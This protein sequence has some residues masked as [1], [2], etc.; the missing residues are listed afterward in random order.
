M[1]DRSPDFPDLNPKAAFSSGQKTVVFDRATLPYRCALD[2]FFLRIFLIDIFAA[3]WRWRGDQ[4]FP[5]PQEFA[6]WLD[7]PGLRICLLRPL[8]MREAQALTASH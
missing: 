2:R 4:L 5:R 3:G 6:V 1:K 8:A 7:G